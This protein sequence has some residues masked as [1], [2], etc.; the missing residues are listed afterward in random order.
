MRRKIRRAEREGLR[1]EEGRSALLLGQFYRLQVI[2]RRRQQLP[3]QPLKW[4]CNLIDCLG[5]QLNIRVAS[6]DGHPVAAIIT[7]RFREVLTYKY[8]C[9]DLRFHRLGGMQFLLWKAIEEAISTGLR[10]FDMGRSD[11]DRPG[12]VTF[13]DRWGAARSKLSYWARPARLIAGHESTWKLDAAKKIFA[14][15][16][17]TCL[18]LAGNL[19]YRHIG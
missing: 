9:S 18:T 5:D 7:L 3:P 8:G 11:L 6:K 1:C 10:E 15:A 4:F 2:S 12:L 19:L 14:H 16:P 17:S 13:K